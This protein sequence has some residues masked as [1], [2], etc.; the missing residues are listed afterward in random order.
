M[1]YVVKH[2]LSD[3]GRVRQVVDHAYGAYVDRLADYD[4]SIQW[5]NDREAHVTFSVMK[6]KLDARFSFDEEEL[7]V[8]GDVPFIFK[9]FQGK[10]EK[11]VG[12]EVNRWLVKAR[13]GEI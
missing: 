8:E 9:P 10:I 1:K 11:I 12:D 7:R 13:A 3:L 5:V 2:Q 6:K 4:P